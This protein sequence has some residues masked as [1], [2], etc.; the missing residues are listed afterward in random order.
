[1]TC[2]PAWKLQCCCNRHQLAGCQAW[3]GGQHPWRKYVCTP[4]H[5]LCR[6]TVDHHLCAICA[7]S[8]QVRMRCDVV[9]AAAVYL[10]VH[11]FPLPLLPKSTRGP[12]HLPSAVAWCHKGVN[13]E[14]LRH[15]VV[16]RYGGKAH[17]SCWNCVALAQHAIANAGF[18]AL[19]WNDHLFIYPPIKKTM[20]RP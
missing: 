5:C 7:V 9:A 15:V 8:L 11:R 20:S 19:K 1:M 10:C 3:A 2:A 6:T 4:Q 16:V 12:R 14:H 17:A 18:P 13:S